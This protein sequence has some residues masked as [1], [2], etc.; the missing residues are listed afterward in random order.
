M[1]S[2]RIGSLLAQD[3]LFDVCNPCKFLHKAEI[4]NNAG[5]RNN[6]RKT[7]KIEPTIYCKNCREAVKNKIESEMRKKK[8]QDCLDPSE[9]SVNDSKKKANNNRH[10]SRITNRNR[11]R[12]ATSEVEKRVTK[13]TQRRRISPRQKS[14]N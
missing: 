8:V 10:N 5:R 1:H 13:P 7:K 2:H 11:K 12:T 3:N 6:A 14:F 9:S 4:T